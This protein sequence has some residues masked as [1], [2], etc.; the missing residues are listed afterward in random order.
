M[1]ELTEDQASVLKQG[2]P[3]RVTVPQLGGVLVIVLAA[4]SES[5]ETV[6]R[7]T[8]A[9]LKERASLAEV[10]RRAAGSWMKDNGF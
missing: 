10:G 4:E 2:Y 6:L 7:E 1:I 8:L 9:D 3:L 5:T